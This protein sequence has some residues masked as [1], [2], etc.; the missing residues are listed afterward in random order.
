MAVDVHAEAFSDMT[1]C[2]LVGGN[3]SFGGTCHRIF[4][5]EAER[6]DEDNKVPRK[7]GS[8]HKYNIF[9]YLNQQSECTFYK[10]MIWLF[11]WHDE[12]S[13]SGESSVPYIRS[14]GQKYNMNGTCCT[15]AK[16]GKEC[17]IF[18]QPPPPPPRKKTVSTQV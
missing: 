9:F 18:V 4:R 2:V 16:Y 8:H 11:P 13:S 14:I 5:V 10:L 1:P 7:F 6:E 17:N 12:E 15:R 3:Q